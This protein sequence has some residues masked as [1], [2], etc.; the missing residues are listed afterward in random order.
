[1][2]SGSCASDANAAKSSR[3]RYPVGGDNVSTNRL[4]LWRLL[5]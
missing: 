3:P 2:W 4:K 5:V 1:M